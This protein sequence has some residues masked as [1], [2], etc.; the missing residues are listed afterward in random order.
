MNQSHLN[1][2]NQNYQSAAMSANVPQSPPL[3]DRIKSR[4]EGLHKITTELHQLSDRMVG[5]RDIPGASN[6]SS[7]PNGMLEEIAD[8]VE[9]LGDRL[10]ALYGRLSR[11]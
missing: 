4:L 2:G 1:Q 9:S 10:D 11:V 8:S 6:V 5:I 3:L 7:I